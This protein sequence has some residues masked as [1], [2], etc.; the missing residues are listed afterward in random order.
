MNDMT[1]QDLQDNT[2]EAVDAA[3]VD[4]GRL[5]LIPMRNVVLFPGL[6]IP[7]TLGRESSMAAAQEAVNRDSRIG[8]LLQSH[9]ETDEPG[10]DDLHRMGTIANIL[11]YVT[12]PDGTH[13]L[14]VQGEQRFRVLDYLADGEHLSA[15]VET[16]PNNEDDDPEIRAR[17]RHLQEKAVE[18]LR[19]LPQAPAEMTAI[20]Q[21]MES[22]GALAD[23]ISNFLDIGP[24]ESRNCWKPWTCASGWTRYP[25]RCAT[26]WKC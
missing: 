24:H 7:I 11:R 1:D 4:D 25:S 6:A 2:A 9:P 16:L 18:T 26:S 19:L 8:L 22:A 12:T 5:I 15:Q 14:V 21:G 13:H 23:L 17:M 3:P 20:I 10:A